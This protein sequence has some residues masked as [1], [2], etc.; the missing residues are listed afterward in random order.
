MGEKLKIVVIDDDAGACL[1]VKKILEKT[2][3]YSVAT[4][5][6]PHEAIDICLQHQPQMIIL[7]NV[8]PELRGSELVKMIKRNSRLKAIPII[9][10]TGKGEMIFSEEKGNFEWQPNTPLVGKRGIL[11]EQ[12]HPKSLK[13]AYGVDDYVSKPLN[14]DVLL[15]AI[16]DIL[17]TKQEKKDL[18]EWKKY[19]I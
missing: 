12:K 18:E 11:E 3:R 14:S 1:L 15:G 13:E 19:N 6:H 16:E 9:M 4:T 17:I 2:K 7:D 5:T 10:L 8:M